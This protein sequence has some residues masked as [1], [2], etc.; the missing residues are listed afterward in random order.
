[1]ITHNCWT[2]I[3]GIVIV[4]ESIMVKRHTQSEALIKHETVGL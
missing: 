3:F 4:C 1:V 2:K